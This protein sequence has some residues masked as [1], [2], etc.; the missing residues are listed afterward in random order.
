MLT[1]A[2]TTMGTVAYMS[3]EQVNGEEVDQRSD[4]WSLGVVL[5]EMLTG[6]LPFSGEYEQAIMYA[7]INNDPKSIKR[8]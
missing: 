2:G 4:I 1:K 8:F 3:P 5:C 7:I 6:Q